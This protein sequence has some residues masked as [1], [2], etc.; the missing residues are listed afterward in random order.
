V[1]VVE[2]RFNVAARIRER[3]AEYPDRKAL[4][5]A[6]ERSRG[7]DATYEH[8]TYRE[9]EVRTDAYAFG[10]AE[11]GMGKGVKTIVL[12]KPDIRL[13]LILTA[14]MKTGAVPIMIDSG[15]GVDNMMRC[16]AAT[17]AEASIG[18][19]LAREL[20]SVR[21]HVTVGNDQFREGYSISDIYKPHE[22]PFP[23]DDP[24]PGDLAII[25]FTT[26]S[27]GPAKGVEN[28]AAGWTAQLE[29]LKRIM[30]PDE[31]EIDLATFP[32]FAFFD[33]VLGNTAVLPDMDP[34]KPAKVNP[35]RIIEAIGDLEATSIFGSPAL[36]DRVGRYA[37]PRGLLFPSVKRVLSG[38]APVSASIM[39][40]F[41]ALLVDAQVFSIYGATECLP[42][43]GVGSNEVLSEINQPG[44]LALGT[45]V[46]RPF[47]GVDITIIKISDEPIAE[48]TDDLPAE[49]GEVGEIMIK[50]AHV[51]TRYLNR[52][53]A[54][55]DHKVRR[56][57]EIWHRMG[58]LGR[59][60]AGGRLWFCG[61]KQQRV[62][63]NEG[64]LFTVPCENIFNAHPLVKRSALAGVD[65]GEGVE[66][67]ICIEPEDN[68]KTDARLVEE[69]REAAMTSEMTG[70]IRRIEFFETFPVD[71][72]HNAKIFRERLAEECKNRMVDPRR[73]RTG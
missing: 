33:I 5:W 19:P 63:T 16:L 2:N 65:L 61:R 31:Q 69:L 20:P 62:I 26:G 12:V 57:N 50:S 10:L 35:D 7:G 8:I 67:V 25:F 1:S 59:L 66:P 64:T 47:P 42:I 37:R 70:S 45:C 3:A 53:D 58:D 72:R 27:T 13:F 21:T 73:T 71:A 43:S 11:A 40:M 51:S 44:Q 52:P 22:E 18:I 60:D 36:L 30:R 46:G 15:M 6:G 29:Q 4:I 9:F 34:S 49:D 28:T 24:D 54:D 14:L 68:V 55:T 17:G 39:G 56:G 23:I 41:S 32:I 48:Y 38:G